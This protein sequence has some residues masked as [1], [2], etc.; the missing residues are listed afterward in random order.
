[1]SLLAE[2][3]CSMA[4]PGRCRRGLPRAEFEAA[5]LA[6]GREAGYQA[7]AALGIQVYIQSQ[8]GERVVTPSLQLGVG[9]LT[10]ISRA[11]FVHFNLINTFASLLRSVRRGWCGG[12]VPSA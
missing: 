8:I 9:P 2:H 12:G 6:A 1:M 7:G 3:I 10:A 4:V 5:A 11:T